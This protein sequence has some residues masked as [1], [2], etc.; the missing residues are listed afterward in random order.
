MEQ[1]LKLGPLERYLA[2]AVPREFYTKDAIC[3]YSGGGLKHGQASAHRRWMEGLEVIAAQ[4]VQAIQNLH[5]AMA[6]LEDLKDRLSKAKDEPDWTDPRVRKE[7]TKKM[8]SITQVGNIGTAYIKNRRGELIPKLSSITYHDALAFY[9][10]QIRHINL[11]EDRSEGLEQALWR[12]KQK[13]FNVDF[14]APDAP[15][16]RI[17]NRVSWIAIPK[18]I[19][20]NA[21]FA[22]T[23]EVGETY[24]LD[25][26]RRL[27]FGRSC[28]TISG[29]MTES[30][31]EY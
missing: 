4:Q 19:N 7:M 30:K 11:R 20:G 27:H 10:G 5:E 14:N 25:R 16:S 23:A 12:V 13:A 21:Q 8:R 17:L 3:T 31:R 22:V 9:K 6:A 24:S 1:D 28:Q 2:R 15:D 26:M 18:H 29:C